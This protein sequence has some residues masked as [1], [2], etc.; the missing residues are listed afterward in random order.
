LDFLCF[1]LKKGGKYGNEET[2]SK[3]KG[4]SEEDDQEG[5]CQEACQKDCQKAREE[6]VRWSIQPSLLHRTR[7][8]MKQAFFSPFLS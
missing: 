2:G 4:G 7:S 1:I 6:E 3:K 8:C 5:C